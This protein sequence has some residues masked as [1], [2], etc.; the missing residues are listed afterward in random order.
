MAT[1]KKTTKETSGKSI[2]ELIGKPT[3]N[4]ADA[5]EEVSKE[6]KVSKISKEP[7][8]QDGEEKALPVP[9]PIVEPTESY[10]EPK[11]RESYERGRFEQA[12]PTQ[13]VSGILDVQPEGH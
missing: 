6:G 5:A 9:P 4:I 10:F 7:E 1:K 8:K 13:P 2:D 11:R 12:G 3:S